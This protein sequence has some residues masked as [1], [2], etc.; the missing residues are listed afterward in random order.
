MLGDRY[1]IACVYVPSS[2]ADLN[3]LGLAYVDLNDPHVVAV[4]VA[5]HGQDLAHHHVFELGGLILHR[6]HLG[7]GEGQG[8][9]KFLI[10]NVAHADA[11]DKFIQPFTG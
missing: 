1:Q 9:G 11:G 10:V 3:R 4:G 8:L 5:L 6:L 7:A 2:G